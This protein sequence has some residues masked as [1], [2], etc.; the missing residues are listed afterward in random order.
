MEIRF[1]TDDEF[2]NELKE[3]TGST[4][5]NVVVEEALALY[6]WALEQKEEG[7]DIFAA[8]S[9]GQNPVRVVLPRLSRVKKKT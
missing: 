2:I 9:N 3:M 8:D 5:S 1:S 6:R 7:K 4:R